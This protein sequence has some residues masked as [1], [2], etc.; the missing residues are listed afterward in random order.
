MASVP[1]EAAVPRLG[2]RTGGVAVAL[3]RHWVAA[4]ALLIIFPATLAFF[5]NQ[6]GPRYEAAATVLISQ[7]DVSA[8]LLGTEAGAPLATVSLATEAQIA[9]LPIVQANAMARAGKDSAAATDATIALRINSTAN[10]L[11]ESSILNVVAQAGE[12]EYAKALATAAAEEYVAFRSE[13]ESRQLRNARQQLAGRLSELREA[14][15]AESGLYGELAGR[16]ELLDTMLVLRGSRAQVL[17]AAASA[18]QIEPRIDRA[19]VQGL[20][21]G[22]VL[23]VLLVLLLER[24]DSRATQGDEV[25]ALLGLPAVGVVPP[26]SEGRGARDD[27]RVR[28]EA[29]R[30]LRNHLKLALVARDGRRVVVTSARPAEGKS[31]TVAAIATAAA[32]AG[33]RVLVVDLDLRRPSL[34]RYFGCDSN[35]GVTDVLAGDVQL[36]QSIQEIRLDDGA[37]PGGRLQF[38][39]A[40]TVMPNAGELVASA[41]VRELVEAASADAQLVLIDSPPLFAVSDASSIASYCDGTLVVVRTQDST[42]RSLEQLRLLVDQGGHRPIGVVVVERTRRALA[43]YQY[44][45]GGEHMER[46]RRGARGSRPRAGSGRSHR[47]DPGFS[48]A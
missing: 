7:K 20:L 14:G 1:D 21:G 8:G 13:V 4:T 33:Q 31:T 11:S 16:L 45:Y 5:S 28:T 37:V 19:I 32:S 48:E 47:E 6:K 27:A 25:A 44:G 39:A 38:L 24:I 3:R 40:G 34:H 2:K 43:Y 22:L 23:A 10:T 12:P 26:I 36:S 29:F 18:A 46:A 9:G 30:A 15:R 41:A 35:Q 42:R 17:Q